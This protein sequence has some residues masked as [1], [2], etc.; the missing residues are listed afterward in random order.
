[1]KECDYENCPYCGKD[2][3]EHIRNSK[4]LRTFDFKPVKDGKWGIQQE[5]K[6]SYKCPHCG[7]K[8]YLL[9]QH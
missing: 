4:C 8:F 1:M 2:I 9:C 5:W 7:E 3:R 6:E